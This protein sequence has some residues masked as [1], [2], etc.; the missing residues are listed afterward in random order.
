MFSDTQP[1]QPAPAGGDDWSRFRVGRPE[2]VAAL[3]RQLR[4]GSVPVVLGAPGGAAFVTTL[5]SL[6]AQAGR[7]HFAAPEHDPQLQTLLGAN[8][9]VAVSYLDAVKLQFDL[10][11]LMLV[12]GRD[13]A[14][15]QAGWPDDL[16]RFQRRASYRV[17]PL[18][19]HAPSAR[20]RH[21]AMPEAQ[22][23]LRVLDISIGGC[24]LLLPDD[25]PAI[26][27]GSVVHGVHIELDAETRFT[28]ALR[29]LHAGSVGAEVA[30]ERLG[31][32]WVQL[33]S[34]AER[35]L[36]RCIDQT[37]KRRRLLSALR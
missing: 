7:L 28:T 14:A 29:I 6:D 24:A 5:W 26:Q 9:A 33:D 34:E 30:G 25:V 10:Q 37:Q 21:P 4:D 3:L 16:Y 17:R 35:T 31:C 15:L 27:P 12:R 36:Q 13:R 11:D 20:L 22:F 19:R 23:T 32:E 18:E 2:E 1:A 8:E